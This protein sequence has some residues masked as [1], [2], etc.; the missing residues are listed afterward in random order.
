MTDMIERVARALC[1]YSEFMWQD[2]IPKAEA[3]IEAMRE[4]T[5]QIADAMFQYHCTDTQSCYNAWRAAID[6]ALKENDDD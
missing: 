4:P 1:S 2:N 3:A 5:E 6:A